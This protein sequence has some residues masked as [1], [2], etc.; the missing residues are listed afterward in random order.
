MRRRNVVMPVLAVALA[1]V[2]EIG[3]AELLTW[4]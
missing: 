1:Q 3:I 4:R 2:L